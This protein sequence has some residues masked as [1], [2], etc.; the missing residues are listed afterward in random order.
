[1]IN[2]YRYIKVGIQ[3]MKIAESIERLYI[4]DVRK[5]IKSNKIKKT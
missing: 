4:T 2:I 5:K 1:M 3:M